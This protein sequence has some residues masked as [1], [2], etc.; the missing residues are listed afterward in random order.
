MPI[1]YEHGFPSPNAFRRIWAPDLKF[2]CRLDEKTMDRRKL[3][4]Q[5]LASALT[6]M[7]GWTLSDAKLHREFRFR[8]FNEAFGFM[9][10]VALVAESLGHPPAWT[11]V[12][13]TVSVDLYSHDV[14][15][16]TDHDLI[17]AG[18]MDVFA[19]ALAPSLQPS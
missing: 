2:R 6:R 5:E 17:L 13:G 15:G 10:R 8:D 7:E 19:R 14:G 18:K 4:E 11:N 16:I 1:V 12:Y 3:S 9:T